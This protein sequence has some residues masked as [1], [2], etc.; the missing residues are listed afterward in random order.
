[1]NLKEKVFSNFAWKVAALLLA[2]VLWF[3]VATEKTYEKTFPVKIQTVGLHK[4]LEVEN[5]ESPALAISTVATGKQL[6]QLMLS[7]GARAYIDLSA[8][9]RPGQ[10][11]FTI[12]LS[13][14]YDIDVSTYR[15]LNL[16][17]PDHLVV[18]V[19]SRT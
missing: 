17:G 7:G 13:D 3:H 4:N 12:S 2:L 10:Y 11:D 6:L 5:I 18:T 8:I 9:S 15:G 1:L 16:I 14:L 19:K